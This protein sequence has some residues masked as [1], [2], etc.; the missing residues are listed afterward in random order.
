ML[1]PN[2]TARMARELDQ[3]LDMA[4]EGLEPAEAVKARAAVLANLDQIMG[5]DAWY[6]MGTRAV[7][8]YAQDCADRLFEGLEPRSVDDFEE[9]RADAAC[10]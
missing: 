9:E 1:S 4:Y 2:L 8:P 6:W 7:G 3:E 5:S 10:R